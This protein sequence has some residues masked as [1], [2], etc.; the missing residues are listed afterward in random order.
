MRSA[1][2][3]TL[4]GEACTTDFVSYDGYGC[5]HSICGA[6]LLRDCAAVAEQ[7]HQQWATEMQDF[8]LD[9]HDACQ[10]W[11]LLHL[12]SVPA[13]ER[14]EWVARYFEILAAGY[15]AQPPPP[16]SSAGL[17]Q[18]PAQ[19]KPG[20]ESAGCAAWA[21]RAS[22]GVARRPA[23]SFYQQPGRA[24]SSLGES[25][26]KDF[27]HLSQCD[28]GYRFL[29]HP[30]LSFDDAQARTFHALCSDCCLPWS[31]FTRRLGT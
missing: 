6:H 24:G 30:Q 25:A 21:C 1:S 3:R 22:A 27:W 10:E 4:Q 19:A 12:T 18:R 7:E 9:L 17:A 8:L 16:A 14:D 23:H 2:G 15:A 20:Q 5:A 11:R 26:A 28:W 31:T 29:P 13:I